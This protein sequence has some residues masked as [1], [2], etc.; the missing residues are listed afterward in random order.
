MSDLLSPEQVESVEEALRGMN[1]SE[2]ETGGEVEDVDVDIE[3]SADSDAEPELDSLDDETDMEDSE[4]GHSVPYTRFSKVIAAKNRYAGE[5]SDLQAQIADM[6]SRDAKYNQ[7]IPQPA[8]R[9]NFDSDE[10]YDSF[11]SSE[12][13]RFDVLETQ[14][15][16]VAVQQEEVKIES[17]LAATVN[18]FPG[19][20]PEFLLNAVIEDPSVDMRDLAEVYTNKV[21]EI[22]EAAVA[23]FLAENPGAAA[24]L[25]NNDVPPEV[26]TQSRGTYRG[27]L[28]QGTMPKTMGEA[29]SAL[30]QWLE[31]Q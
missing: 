1:D 31:S 24:E 9:S 29:H 25:E 30:A 22:E 7:N 26:S 16:E 6:E 8:P 15:R 17:E 12:D 13:T 4:D 3:V 14:M 27:V 10:E 19:V 28:K 5:V 11:D 21:A 18:E 20:D 2:S 23:R